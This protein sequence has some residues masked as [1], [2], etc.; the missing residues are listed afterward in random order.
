MTIISA[1]ALIIGLMLK[2]H[3]GPRLCLKN[4]L[5]FSKMFTRLSS[6]VWNLLLLVSS[7]KAIKRLKKWLY[8]DFS[9]SNRN[10]SAQDSALKCLV[11]FSFSKTG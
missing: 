10:S 3:G 2:K 9:D 7:D 5:K 1:V 11:F 4:V 8:S 6:V